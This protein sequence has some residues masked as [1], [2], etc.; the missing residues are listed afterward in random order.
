MSG[1]EPSEN[2]FAAIRA[3]DAEG[4]VSDR[5]AWEQASAPP[6]L[7]EVDDRIA[8][9][10]HDRV[11]VRIREAELALA[12]ILGLGTVDTNVA[13]QLRDVLD[14][15][16]IAAKDLRSTVHALVVHQHDAPPDPTNHLTIVTPTSNPAES[17][18]PVGVAGRRYLCSFEDGQV[19][20]Y[21]TPAGHDFF[22][23]VDHMPWAHE[24]DGLLLSARSG[25]PLARRAGTLFHDIVS[26]VPL[27]YERTE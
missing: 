8:V 3:T 24:S 25:A 21:A 12:A 2:G 5:P 17:A 7:I 13:A 22:R 15:L 23:A 16:D 20:A 26:N 1:T 9:H 27:Y 14:D 19:F 10:M 4:G 11:I 18:R 6:S